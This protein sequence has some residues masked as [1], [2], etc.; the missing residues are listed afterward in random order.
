MAFRDSHFTA[1]ATLL[2]CGP[3]LVLFCC[4]IAPRSLLII[5]ALTRYVNVASVA[6][7]LWA[8]APTADLNL[9]NCFVCSAFVWASALL[10]VSALLQGELMSPR[11]AQLATVQRQEAVI[12]CEV[13]VV[14]RLADW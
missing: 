10:P 7:V 6:T 8:W 1:A 12:P 13:Y 5:V 3:P 11:R 9:T 2:Q 14:C 4:I